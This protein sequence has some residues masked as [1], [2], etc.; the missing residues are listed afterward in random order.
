MNMKYDT[1]LGLKCL[2]Y[3][4]GVSSLGKLTNWDGQSPP[5]PVHQLGKAVITKEEV[6]QALPNFGSYKKIKDQKMAEKMYD[7]DLLADA[8]KPN[9]T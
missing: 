2:L 1:F 6:G 5:T 7:R 4:K 3:L 9:N 8:F